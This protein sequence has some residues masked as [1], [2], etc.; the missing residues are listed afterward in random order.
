MAEYCTNHDDCVISYS[1]DRAQP[2]DSPFGFLV[3]LQSDDGPGSGVVAKP[4][5]LTRLAVEDGCCLEPQL[6]LLSGIPLCGVVTESGFW[7]LPFP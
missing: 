7:L 5:P 3:Q 6:G 2:G 1:S 4:S